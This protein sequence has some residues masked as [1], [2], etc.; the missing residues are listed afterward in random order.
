MCR[1]TVYGIK[2]TGICEAK[3]SLAD[4]KESTYSLLQARELQN[5]MLKEREN[6]RKIGKMKTV[7]QNLMF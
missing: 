2:T 6:T 1:S 5:T 4:E 7:V 3:A